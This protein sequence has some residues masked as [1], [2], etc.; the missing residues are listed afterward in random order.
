M[1]R[2]PNI[3]PKVIAAIPAYN[4]ERR[5]GDLVIITRKYVSQVIVID[6]GSTDET[7]RAAN[8]S[9]AL[10]LRH[11]VNK[12]YGEAIRH[13]FEAAKENGGDVLVTLDGDGQHDPSEIPML[14][15]PI[16]KNEANLVIG[17]RLLKPVSRQTNMP[18]Y[19][20]FGIAFI[21][22]LFNIGS[23][24]RVSDAQSGF[25]AYD[26]RILDNISLTETGMAVSVEVIVKAREKG[27]VIREVPISCRYDSQSSTFNP[28]G[29]G[30]GV[31]LALV[32][33]RSESLLNRLGEKNSASG[34]SASPPT[35]HT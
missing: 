15:G 11:R 18:M 5:I 33:L 25:R 9:G 8:A 27:F 13:C 12:G 19:R 24:V 1:V 4:E 31:A 22:M 17:S 14:V 20:K 7:C 29:H 34:R 16:L 6:D 26:R 3:P 30:L 23:R 28:V 2:P 35:P 21:T 10:V 32:K